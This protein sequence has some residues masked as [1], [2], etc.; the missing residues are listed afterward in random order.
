MANLHD[1]V[2]FNQ[3]GL[4]EHAAR[5]SMSITANLASVCKGD[6]DNDGDVDGSDLAVFT[7]DFDRTDCEGSVDPCEV[8]FDGDGDVDGSDPA[9]FAADFGR[10]DCP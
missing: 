8:N 7:A 5:W 4:E 2:H 9:V 3:L 10:T 1:G 6:H